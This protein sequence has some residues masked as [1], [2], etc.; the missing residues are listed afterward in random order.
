MSLVIA[1]GFAVPNGLASGQQGSAKFALISADGYR[2]VF[3]DSS[4]PDFIAPLNGPDAVTGLDGAEVRGSSEP[5]PDAH[6]VSSG[7]SYAGER[8]ITMAGQIVPQGVT[9]TAAKLD[10]NIKLGKLRR[11]TGSLMTRQG[12]LI[13]Q[14]EGG[15]EMVAAVRLQAPVRTP[16]AWVKDFQLSLIASDPLIYSREWTTV[17]RGP[18]N[19]FPLP[20]ILTTAYD[21]NGSRVEQWGTEAVRGF[22][23][24]QGSAG[25]ILDPNDPGAPFVATITGVAGTN[26]A[27]I[28]QT[29]ESGIFMGPLTLAENDVLV[30]DSATGDV[31]FN[32]SNANGVVQ[33]PLTRWWGLTHDSNEIRLAFSSHSSATPPSFSITY[34]H[35]WL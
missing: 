23:T 11:V 27:L 13:W 9:D 15:F 17:T 7:P 26:P 21:L 35:S 32:G 25:T 8:P 10:R 34:R 4:D 5:R 18:A 12:Q 14:P 28:N 31:T 33:V 6:G 2:I 16:G 19:Y 30:I 29:N 1:P 24:N 22:V 20:W 3:N